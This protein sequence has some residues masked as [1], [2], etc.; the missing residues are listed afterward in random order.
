MPSRTTAGQ[1]LHLAAAFGTPEVRLRSCSSKTVRL[2]WTPSPSTHNPTSPCTQPWLWDA[3]RKPSGCFLPSRSRPQRPPD[4]RLHGHL[5]SA[6]AANRR[7]LV[8]FLIANGADASNQERL[9]PDRCSHLRP[10]AQ[11]TTELAKLARKPESPKIIR[12]PLGLDFLDLGAMLETLNINSPARLPK[13][14]AIPLR[15]PEPSKPPVIASHP[16]SGRS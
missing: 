12:V 4:C 14:H 16:A 13:L 3:T 8:E 11:V 1:P 5:F 9:Q 2:A 7:D 10:R 6:A 15:I